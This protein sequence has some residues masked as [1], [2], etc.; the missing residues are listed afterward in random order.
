MISRD[1][2]SVS[3]KEITRVSANISFTAYVCF[4]L[5][6]TVINKL[7]DFPSRVA[8]AKVVKTYFLIKKSLQQLGVKHKPE[9]FFDCT[10]TSIKFVSKF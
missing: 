2:K 8:N 5:I 6:M 3:I 10:E 7:P 4:V 9:I 1:W